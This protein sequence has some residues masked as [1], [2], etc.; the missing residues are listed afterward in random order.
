MSVDELRSAKK[1]LK[2]LSFVDIAVKGVP[3]KTYY[4]IDKNELILSILRLKDVK[5]SENMAQQPVSGNSPNLYREKAQTIY[6][7]NTQKKEFLNKNSSSSKNRLTNNIE[8]PDIVLVDEDGNELSPTGFVKKKKRE[9]KNKVALRIQRKFLE[10][11]KKEIGQDIAETSK[12][13]F[14]VLQAMNKHK[15]T[16]EQILDLFDE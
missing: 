8:D 11:I 13:Y 4:K 14:M 5:S 6:T 15:L 7:E 2:E 12:G 1:K 10:M 3:A 9:P 16:E